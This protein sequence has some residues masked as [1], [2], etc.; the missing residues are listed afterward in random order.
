MGHLGRATGLLAILVTATSL[1][2]TLQLGTESDQLDDQDKTTDEEDPAASKPAKDDPGSADCLCT[3]GTVV[4]CPCESSFGVQTCQ[5]DCRSFSAC[6]CESY[7]LPETV[8]I[9]FVD[10]LIAPFDAHEEYWDSHE[11][12]DAAM[13]S[14]LA[15]ALGAAAPYSAVLGFVASYASD[16]YALPDPYGYH[17]VWDGDNWLSGELVDESCNFENT[18]HPMWPGPGWHHVPVEPN[19][20]LRVNLFDED[21]FNDD[22]IGTAEI[23]YEDI[24]AALQAGEV[25]QVNVANQTQNQLLFVGI[26]V[27]PE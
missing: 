7:T 25:Y 9:T 1:G 17:Q 5:V 24:V 3:P 16:A 13:V 19:M 11:Q 10:A 21:L 15:S 27:V 26:S 4:D 18:L 20:R 23:N 2:C 12:V 6:E 22:P 14:G 8:T